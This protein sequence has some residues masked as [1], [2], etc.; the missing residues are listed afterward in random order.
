M[1]FKSQNGLRAVLFDMDGVIVDSE[2]II[3][4]AAVLF[5]K[6]RGVAVKGE[7]FHPFIGTG[8]ARYLGGVAE[9]YGVAIDPESAK[10]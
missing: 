1:D 4:K 5:F 2:S 6:E 7:D 8:E 10:K 3:E 9:K